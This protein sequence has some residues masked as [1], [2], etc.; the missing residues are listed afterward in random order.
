M[1]LDH[2]DSNHLLLKQ[3]FLNHVSIQENNI[4]HIKFKGTPDEMATE[5]ENQL[6]NIPGLKLTK[7][8]IIQFDVKTQALMNL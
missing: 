3:T 8:K 2:P 7:D 5:Y 1:E 4:H 6:R